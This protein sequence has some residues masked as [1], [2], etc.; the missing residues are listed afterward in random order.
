MS[1][2][3]CT[4]FGDT[5]CLDPNKS[6]NYQDIDFDWFTYC[7]DMWLLTLLFSLQYLS[8]SCFGNDIKF[9]LPNPWVVLF[10]IYPT[11]YSLK[12]SF[13]QPFSLLCHPPTWPTINNDRFPS[14]EIGR[15][16]RNKVRQLD[17]NVWTS[18]VNKYSHSIIITNSTKYKPSW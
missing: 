9:L 11:F 7:I 18:F 15:E 10:F 14:S 16:L 3:S 5:I 12:I 4:F 1:A 8:E 17:F 6:E 13:T 2:Q